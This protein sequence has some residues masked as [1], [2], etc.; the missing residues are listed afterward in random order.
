MILHFFSCGSILSNATLNRK[1]G[2]G[3]KVSFNLFPSTRIRE[4]GI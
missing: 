4:N 1:I 2:V 3:R